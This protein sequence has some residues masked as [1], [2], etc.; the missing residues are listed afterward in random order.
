MYLVA[1]F[2]LALQHKKYSCNVFRLHLFGFETRFKQADCGVDDMIF[3]G[4]CAVPKAPHGMR[5]SRLPQAAKRLGL[6]EGLYGK[7][8]PFVYRGVGM[9]R[10]AG[11]PFG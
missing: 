6:S 2:F 3:P 10:E 9:G 1:F 7:M 5:L 8:P 11:K 4:L